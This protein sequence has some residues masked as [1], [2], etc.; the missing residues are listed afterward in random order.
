MHVSRLHGR[1][2]LHAIILQYIFPCSVL[3]LRYL[4]DLFQNLEWS[5]KDL[6]VPKILLL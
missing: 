2:I 1:Y 4:A 5:V 3:F 6:M